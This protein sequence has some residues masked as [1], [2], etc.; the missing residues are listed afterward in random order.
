M[1]DEILVAIHQPNFLPWLGWWDKLARAD[2]LVLL[3]D[4]QFPKTGATYINRVDILRHDHAGPIT[5]PV[6]RS[7]SGLRTVAQMR[8]D[9]QRPWRAK[10]LKTLQTYYGRA[11]RFTETIELLEPLLLDDTDVL[12]DYNERALRALASHLH[13]GPERFVRA[14]TLP[15]EGRSTH[16]LV[17]LVRAC[18][19]TAY[20]EGGGAREYQEDELFARAGLR[21][22]RQEFRA[23]PYPQGRADGFVPGLSVVDALM[24]LGPAET[25]SLLSA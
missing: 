2:A 19:G 16:R 15:S 10:M 22:V 17:S 3:D 25:R 18:G 7:Y 23:R 21:V 5:V 4:V 14:S 11:P 1:P 12:L 9:V 13:L 20:L 6:T 8:T 24:W